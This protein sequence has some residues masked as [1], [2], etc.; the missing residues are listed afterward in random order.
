MLHLHYRLELTEAAEADPAGFWA[1]AAERE[2]WF[3]EGLDTVLATSWHLRTVGTHV[4]ALEHL[5]TFADEAAWGTYRRQVSARSKDPSWEERRTEQ[6]HWWRLAEAAL[7]NDPPVAMGLH[8][9]P[10]PR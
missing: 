1:W 5:V 10:P 6:T 2:K 4:H 8:R 9:A 7:L 3:Y